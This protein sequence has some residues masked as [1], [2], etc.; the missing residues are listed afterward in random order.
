MA[1]FVLR[2]GH[3]LSP[4]KDIGLVIDDVEVLNDLSSIASACAMLLGLTYALNLSD[5]VELKYTFW[6]VKTCHIVSMSLYSSQMSAVAREN[7]VIQV[8]QGQILWSHCGH[9]SLS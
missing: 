1:I 3:D 2:D 4:P 6:G 8:C 9:V 7:I 5:P